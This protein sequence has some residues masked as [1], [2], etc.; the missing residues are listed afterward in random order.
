MEND[1]KIS[2]LSNETKNYTEQINDFLN[3]INF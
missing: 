3:E 1:L 2:S